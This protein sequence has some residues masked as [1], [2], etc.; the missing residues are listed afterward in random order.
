ME[1]TYTLAKFHVPVQMY[2]ELIPKKRQFY[3]ASNQ[4]FPT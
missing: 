1:L 3:C 2:I 4:I